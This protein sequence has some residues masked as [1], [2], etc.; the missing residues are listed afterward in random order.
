MNVYNTVRVT[1]EN[2]EFGE[3][4]TKELEVAKY[5]DLVSSVKLTPEGTEKEL[6]MQKIL[7]ISQAD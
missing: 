7:E 3:I 4:T 2:Q 6:T 1:L 5:L